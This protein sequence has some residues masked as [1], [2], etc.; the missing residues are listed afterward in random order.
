MSLRARQTLTQS[1]GLYAPS[2]Q[3]DLL[4]LYLYLHTNREAVV[5]GACSYHKSRTARFFRLERRQPLPDR[6]YTIRMTSMIQWSLAEIEYFIVS[7]IETGATL[8]FAHSHPAGQ[9]AF[10][11]TD[12]EGYRSIQTALA[13][14]FGFPMLILSSIMMPDRGLLVRSIHGNGQITLI[15]EIRL[16]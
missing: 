1:F 9:A 14:H 13:S 12:D 10:S 6:A 5:L 7:E 16:P 2:D 8:L 3:R 11:I 15:H 4:Y